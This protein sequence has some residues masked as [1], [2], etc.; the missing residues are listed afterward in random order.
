MNAKDLLKQLRALTE[1]RIG[2]IDD[3]LL[4]LMETLDKIAPKLADL[5]AKQVISA[6]DV[7]DGVIVSS[8]VNQNKII[9]IDKVISDFMKSEGVKVISKMANDLAKITSLNEKYFSNLTGEKID[10]SKVK[11]VI[12]NRLGMDDE[13][14]LKRNG[15][16]KG[17]FDMQQPRRD[18]INYAME[19]TTTG[20]GYEDLR[21]GLREL[22]VGNEDKMG[23]F[24]QFY[25]NAAYDTYAKIDALNGK[26]YADKLTLNYFIY[27]GTRRK[28]SRHFCIERKGKLFSRQEAETWKDLIGTT[29]VDEKG[30]LVPAGPNTY[31]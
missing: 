15:F 17:L 3:S 22:I 27:A 21:K 1:E 29:T 26:L 10:S 2:F 20:T 18:I 8:T 4:K 7:K 28:T 12:Y 13:G 24:K 11:N 25:R 9:G 23:K 19:K 6:L 14:N 30:K 5:I 31:C 16:M